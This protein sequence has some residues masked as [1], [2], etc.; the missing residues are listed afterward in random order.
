MKTA[1]GL[2]FFASLL[3]WACCIY[4]GLL[5]APGYGVLIVGAAAL[6][7]SNAFA[8]EYYLHRRRRHCQRSEYEELLEEPGDDEP[9]LVLLPASSHASAPVASTVPQQRSST[10]ASA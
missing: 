8:L 2:G 9:R 1:F 7:I 4:V 10:A 5:G 3:L 6:C